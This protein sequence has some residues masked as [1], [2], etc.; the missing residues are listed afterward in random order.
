M[1]VHVIYPHVI[2]KKKYHTGGKI[3]KSKIQNV[4]R[5]KMYTLNTPIHD[6]ALSIIGTGTTIRSGGTKLVLCFVF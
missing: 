4:E 1:D 2:I 6:R 5:C 3:S